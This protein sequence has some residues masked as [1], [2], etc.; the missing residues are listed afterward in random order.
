MDFSLLSCAQTHR[1]KLLNIFQATAS[2]VILTATEIE[3]R[4]IKD[5]IMDG[6]TMQLKSVMDKTFHYPIYD[7]LEFSYLRKKKRMKWASAMTEDWRSRHVS[8]VLKSI[9]LFFWNMSFTT[10]SCLL[11]FVCFYDLFFSNCSHRVTNDS[12]KL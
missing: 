5:C 7:L 8:N 9:N 12:F 3:Q 6:K 2:S 10:R 11:W 4:P 1:P